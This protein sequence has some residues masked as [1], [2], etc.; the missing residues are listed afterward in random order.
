MKIP[1]VER[2]ASCSSFLTSNSFFMK[3]ST[4]ISAALIFILLAQPSP[5]QL[6]YKA[7]GPFP[8]D[9]ARRAFVGECA[10][11]L[12]TLKARMPAVK[13]L[14]IGFDAQKSDT[15]DWQAILDLCHEKSYQVVVSFFDSL[16]PSDYQ[17]YRPR[18][19]GGR[20]QLGPLEKFVK[21]AKCVGH[22]ALYALFSIDEP[23]VAAHNPVYTTAE[24]KDL[25]ATLKGLAPNHIAFKIYAQ[26]SRTIWKQS[27]QGRRNNPEVYWDAGICDVVQ[28][29]TLEFQDSNYQFAMLDSNHY[30]SRQ[31]IHRVTPEMPLWTSVQVF[32]NKYGP[33]S[34]YW[35]PR[36]RNGFNDL[37]TLLNDITRPRYQNEHP[38]FGL[39]LQAWDS[40][41]TTVR[42]FHYRL[43]DRDATGEVVSQKEASADAIRAINRWIQ[44]QPTAVESSSNNAPNQYQLAQNYPNP[45]NPSTVISF[46]LPVNSHVTLEV[47]DVLGREVAT[48]VDGEM[49]AGIHAVTFAPL[50]IRPTGFALREVAGGIYF[51]QL[52]AGKFSQTRKAVVMK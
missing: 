8:I 17:G 36:E 2:G 5:A 10:S 9:L 30:Y 42:P 15:S 35:F 24:L 52:T 6:S 50:D 21:N 32:G 33:N 19:S 27:F 25:Y 48:L 20:W 1:L 41:S 31:I 49:T 45:F 12:D 37:T 44:S 51:Y 16:A 14:S 34:G 47:F 11:L 3:R 40:P 26:F 29:S 43:W 4:L 7:D 46:Q 39:A 38:L 22:P 13:Y 28:I 18:K 23:W